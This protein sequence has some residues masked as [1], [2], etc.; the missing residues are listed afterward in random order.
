MTNVHAEIVTVDSSEDGSINQSADSDG[1]DAKNEDR[2]SD[3]DSLTPKHH[4][5][6]L[7]HNTKNNVA[8]RKLSP[9]RF[10]DFSD[11]VKDNTK[12]ND[13][14][15]SCDSDNESDEKL[16]SNLDSVKVIKLEAD[17]SNDSDKDFHEGLEV[18]FENCQRNSPVSL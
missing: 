14:K 17:E 4:S 7:V 13:S 11:I 2:I 16:G 18:H 6:A 3:T 12:E 1:N 9:L 15:E 5:A 10:V 8:R